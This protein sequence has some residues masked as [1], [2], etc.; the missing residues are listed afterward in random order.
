MTMKT[1]IEG[2]RGTRSFTFH[3]ALI[4]L[5]LAAVLVRIVIALVLPRVI[6]FD[7]SA[8]LMLGYNLVNGSGYT[9]TRIYPDTHQ[10]PLYPII[11]GIFFLL[12]R[13][14]E[15]ASNLAYALFGGLLLLPVFVIAQRVYGSQTAWLV[16]VLLAIFPPLSIS[17]L[18]WGGMTEP[19][20]LFL[21][22][23][24]LAALLVG[25]EDNRAG[26]FTAGGVLLGLAYLTRPEAIVYFG[27]ILLFGSVWLRNRLALSGFLSRYAFASFILSFVLVAAPY[28]WYLHSHTGQWTVSGKAN[29]T[30]QSFDD[31]LAGDWAAFDRANW[32][33]DSSGKEVNWDSPD[34]FKG[35]LLQ[36]VLLADPARF[37]HRVMLN[38]YQLKE[39][40]FVKHVFWYG[41]LPLVVLAFFKEP[42]DRKRLMHEAFLITIIIVLLLVFLPFGIMV[43]YF[44]P[45]FPVLLMW[46]ARGALGVGAW[47]LDTLELLRGMPVSGKSMKA[48]LGWMPGAMVVVFL[49]MTVPVVAQGHLDGLSLGEKKAGLWLREHSAADAGIISSDIA[50]GLY[51]NRRYVPSPNTD[52]PRFLQYARSHSADYLVTSS[53]EL[54]GFRPQLSFLLESGAPELELVFSFEESQRRWLVYRISP[55]STKSTSTAGQTLSDNPST[56]PS[57]LSRKEKLL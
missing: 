39:Q 18:Y 16:A 55:S 44:A 14:F 47:V 17:V 8:Y 25:F 38:C 49:L 15:Q 27:V 56:K 35:S 12:V 46:T 50:V 40:L 26:M 13:D 21:L 52:W 51:A 37:L 24:G 4:G 1:G 20:F 11:S 43:R 57:D 2:V 53:R 28:I 31:I 42:W 10:P 9:T 41:L 22:Y 5:V 34:R 45:A 33:L 7:E 19:L 30:V 6:K 32:G 23:G 3:P 48:V 29:G 54:T 36:D